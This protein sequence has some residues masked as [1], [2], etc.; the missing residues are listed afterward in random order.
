MNTQTTIERLK[1]LR[2]RAMSDFYHRS[3]QDPHF[4]KYTL[5]EFLT[6]W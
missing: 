4:P 1:S 3:L 6:Q 2:L 5:D